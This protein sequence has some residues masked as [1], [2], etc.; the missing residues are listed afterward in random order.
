VDST[1]P[2]LTNYETSI[3]NFFSLPAE[4][5]SD[6]NLPIFVGNYQGYCHDYIKAAVVVF[7]ANQNYQPTAYWTVKGL[8]E[9]DTDNPYPY[10]LDTRDDWENMI[11]RLSQNSF[12]PDGEWDAGFAALKISNFKTQDDYISVFKDYFSDTSVSYVYTD[13]YIIVAVVVACVIIAAAVIAVGIYLYRKRKR[14][15]WFN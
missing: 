9:D 3:E 11:R 7:Q 10:V 1:C 2:F 6:D 5:V 14:E 12:L 4:Y 13:V 15:L 8:P